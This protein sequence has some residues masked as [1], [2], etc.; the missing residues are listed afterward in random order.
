VHVHYILSWLSSFPNWNLSA[1]NTYEYVGEKIRCHL[2]VSSCLHK[3]LP[4]WKM[5]IKSYNIVVA[6]D[7][8]IFTEVE[9]ASVKLIHWRSITSIFVVCRYRF[10]SALIFDINFEDVLCKSLSRLTYP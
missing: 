9:N 10:S 6:T 5:C 3:Y 7:V 4:G 8:E 2:A 1:V